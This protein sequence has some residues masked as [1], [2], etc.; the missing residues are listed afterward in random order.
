MA[1]A[2]VPDAAN[3]VEVHDP[4]FV[5]RA[6]Q[7]FEVSDVT[8]ERTTTTSEIVPILLNQRDVLSVVPRPVAE[9]EIVAVDGEAQ[10]AERG[11]VG[12]GEASRRPDGERGIA[13]T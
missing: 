12:R 3:P 4:S 9:P 7:P 10:A 5:K 8:L 6:P 13:P 1:D 11:V 2:D